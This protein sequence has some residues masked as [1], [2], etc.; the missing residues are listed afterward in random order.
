MHLIK[1]ETLAALLLLISD[2]NYLLDVGIDDEY[3]LESLK[4]NCEQLE[5]YLQEITPIKERVV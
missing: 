3:E 2:I 1:A 4:S 5:M